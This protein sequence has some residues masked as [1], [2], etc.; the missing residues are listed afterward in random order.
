VRILPKIGP[1]D[2]LRFPAPAP[3][4]EALFETSFNRTMDEYRRLLADVGAG[5]MS[6]PDRNLDTGRPS[7][8]AE[9]RLADQ[10]WARLARTLAARDP[11]AVDAGI[12]DGVLEFY[13]DPSLP[14]ATRKDRKAWARTLAA[15]DKLKR[16]APPAR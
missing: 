11:A 13:R 9:Y 8:P 3:R 12:R 2:A 14:L 7:A 16:G 6:L 4:T 1:L 5:R 10:A 15:V